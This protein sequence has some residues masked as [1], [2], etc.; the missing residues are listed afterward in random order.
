MTWHWLRCK[1]GK[2]IE[3]SQLGKDHPSFF[4]KH[5]DPECTHQAYLMCC[6]E[7]KK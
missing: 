3:L 7:L 4:S 1:Y 2:W 5:K 6:E